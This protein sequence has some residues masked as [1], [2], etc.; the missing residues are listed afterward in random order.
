MLVGLLGCRHSSLPLKYLGLPLGAKFKE[1]SI[2]NPILEK[3]ERRLACWKWLYISKGGRVTL[4]KSTLT[5][6][7]TYFLSILLVP[8]K[9]ANHMEK[10]QRDFLWSGMN[11]DSKFHLVKWAKVCKPMQVGGL[12]IK[13]LRSFNTAL[14]GKWLWSYALETNTLWKRVIEAKYGNIWG[15]WCMKKVTSPYDVSLWRF[16]RSGWVNFPKLL[17]YDVGDGTRVKFWKHVWCGN[18]SLKEAFLELY[19]LSRARDS[20]VAKVMGWSGGQLYWNF[21]FRHSPQDWEEESFDRFMDIVYSLKV[22]GAGP[23]KVCWKLTR[24]RG[25][26][27]SSFYLSFYPPSISFPWRL[28]WQSKVSP[29]VAF[30]SWSTSLG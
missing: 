14:L 2:W 24:S 6:L 17:W 23:D 10:L 19:S 20:S 22:L 21:H 11:G 7:P 8:G 28:V 5:S 13:R 27:V 16:I 12:G 9:V 26:E 29:R 25:F 30:F 1:V 3:M 18:C 4:I 15:G